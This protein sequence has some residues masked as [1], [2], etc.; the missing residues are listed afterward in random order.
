MT[1]QEL[2][3]R[4]FIRMDVLSIESGDETNY[5]YYTYTFSNDLSIISCANDEAVDNNWNVS[6][7]DID[8]MYI[9]DMAELNVFINLIEKW[10]RSQK[11]G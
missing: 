8:D 9:H 2:I 1:E 3:E 4:G 10:L 11:C 6:I 5:H 7:D